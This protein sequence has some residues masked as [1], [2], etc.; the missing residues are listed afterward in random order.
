MPPNAKA[1]AHTRDI[2]LELHKLNRIPE[3]VVASADDGVGIY[4]TSGKKYAIIECCNDGGIVIGVSDR[5]GDI[6]NWE[7]T[8][9]SHIIRTGLEEAL[10]FLD[11]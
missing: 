1:E 10:V 6:R 11:G 3:R 2:L 8:P 9:E 7:I 4:L 5:Q